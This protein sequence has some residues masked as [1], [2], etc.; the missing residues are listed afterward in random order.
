MLDVCSVSHFLTVMNKAATN[1]FVFGW[2]YV[3]ISP[4][5]HLEEELLGPVVS[6]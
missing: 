3:V 6:V 5:K 2:T 1:I 4:D